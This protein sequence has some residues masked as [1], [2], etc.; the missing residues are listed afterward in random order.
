MVFSHLKYVALAC[1]LTLMLTSRNESMSTVSDMIQD[2]YQLIY[3]RA[4]EEV[5][6]STAQEAVELCE[7]FFISHTY[8]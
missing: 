2:V 3:D 1:S 6:A 7:D 8:E 4:A 5:E